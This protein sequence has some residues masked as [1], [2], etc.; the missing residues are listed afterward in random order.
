MY[1]DIK[2]LWNMGYERTKLLMT[3]EPFQDELVIA[4]CPFLPLGLL[5]LAMS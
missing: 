2:E 1:K 5:I 4:S 3:K